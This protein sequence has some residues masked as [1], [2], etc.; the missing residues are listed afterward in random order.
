MKKAALLIVSVLILVGCGDAPNELFREPLFGDPI[1]T[2]IRPGTPCTYND[3]GIL[4]Y[5]RCS[6]DE[7]CFQVCTEE[8]VWSDCECNGSSK[9]DSG[10]DS[11]VDSDSEDPIETDGGSDAGEEPK[12][13]DGGEDPIEADGGSDAGDCEEADECSGGDAGADTTPQGEPG[14]GCVGS[15]EVDSYCDYHEK[16]Y[17]FQYLS[18]SVPWDDCVQ[19]SGNSWCCGDHGPTE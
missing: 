3:N 10:A 13:E 1:P 8:L 9:G 5:S 12:E 2:Y 15:G 17:R 6:Y 4:P 7:P 18:C 14:E 19:I 16:T 11:D